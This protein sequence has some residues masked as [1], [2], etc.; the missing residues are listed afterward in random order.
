MIAQN[1]FSSHS[2][3]T[4]RIGLM[5]TLINHRYELDYKSL[6]SL[7]M[8]LGRTGEPSIMNAW[9]TNRTWMGFMLHCMCFD[10]LRMFFWVCFFPFL[11]YHLDILSVLDHTSNLLDWTLDIPVSCQGLV[12]PVF[13]SA[14]WFSLIN[15]LCSSHNRRNFILHIYT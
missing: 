4:H 10:I 15:F 12:I 3:K 1:V 9:N 8:S 2:L 6:F 7:N 13:K 14:S 11:Y 5:F